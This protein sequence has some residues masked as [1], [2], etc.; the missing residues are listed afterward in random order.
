MTNPTLSQAI[1]EYLAHCQAA[2]NRAL[3]L[4]ANERNLVL[5]ACEPLS[6]RDIA[7]IKLACLFTGVRSSSIADLRLSDV[8]SGVRRRRMAYRGKGDRPL[9]MSANIE[10]WEALRK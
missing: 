5:R 9:V 10:V 2:A 3:R 7:V 4:T 8:E 1:A 6:A